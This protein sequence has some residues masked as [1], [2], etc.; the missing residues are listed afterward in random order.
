MSLAFR[1]SSTPISGQWHKNIYQRKRNKKQVFLFNWYLQRFFFFNFDKNI[2]FYANIPFGLISN[3]IILQ[4]S[5]WLIIWQSLVLVKFFTKPNM[6]SRLISNTLILV[7]YSARKI[8]C[9][10]LWK[11]QNKLYSVE[12]VILYFENPKLLLSPDI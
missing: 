3:D 7:A 2:A 4:Y 11:F 12:N 1:A 8:Q 9:F 10:F 6:S 5:A